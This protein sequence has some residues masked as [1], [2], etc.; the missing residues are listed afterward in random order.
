MSDLTDFRAAKDQ[1]FRSDPQSPLLPQQ[2]ASFQGLT[3]YD[4]NPALVIEAVPEPFPDQETIEMQTSTGDIASYVRWS[5][6]RFE[7]DGEE[8]ALT[9]FRD[10]GSGAL[11][12]PFQDANAGGETYGAG[13]YLEVEAVDGGRLQVDFNYAYNP[14]CAYN[15]RWSCPIP[16]SEN[17][18]TVAVRAGEQTFANSH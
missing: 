16:P 2:Q 11:F 3:Y 7:V 12:L 5:R 9:V 17:R 13:R 14:Y 15:E 10:A 1:F 4:E 18:L 8:A 6:I